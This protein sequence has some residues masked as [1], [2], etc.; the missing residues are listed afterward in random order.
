[1]RRITLVVLLLFLF[2]NHSVQADDGETSLNLPDLQWDKDVNIGYISTAP[3]VTQGLVIVKG[4]GSNSDGIN[5]TIVAYRADNG[6]EVWRATH[7]TSTYNFEISPLVYVPA[8]T[9]PCS[10]TQ[11]MIVTGWTSGQL[12]AHDLVDGT[13]LWNV[14]TPAPLW[15]ITAQGLS[16]ED[17]LIWPT[18]TGIIDVC[19]ANGTMQ[20]QY[21]NNSIRTYRANIGLWYSWYN[22]SMDYGFLQGTESG[23]ILRYDLNLTLIDQLNVA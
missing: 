14:S 16:I 3:L 18:E 15:G 20:N 23:D 17:R 6:S 11:D 19:A 8:G 7:P 22:F 1:M 21:Q 9:L 2:A 12:T 13:P 4:G 5:P 10:P